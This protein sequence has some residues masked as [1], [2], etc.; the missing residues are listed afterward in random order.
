[1]KAI[2]FDMDGVLIDALPYVWKSFCFVL[3]E[4]NIHLRPEDRAIYLGRP[5]KDTLS[6]LKQNFGLQQYTPEE[7]SRKAGTIEL[8]LMKHE[9][10]PNK[11]LRHKLIKAKKEGTK[12]AVATTSMRWR[13]ET[14]LEALE[15]RDLFDALITN[16]DV[17]HHKPAPDIYLRAA[18]SLG[19]K[20]EDCVV[21]EDA[22]NGVHA[23]KAAGMKVVWVVQPDMQLHADYMIRGVEELDL[24]VV[25][26][27]C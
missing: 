18:Q 16:D 8:Q 22:P 14:I 3:M 11:Y 2:I 17:V 6:L 4:H 1:M 10:V 21:V 27:L 23:A 9:L 7:F 20:P 25:K 5:I 12:L 26:N 19:V 13:A 24:E 15:L